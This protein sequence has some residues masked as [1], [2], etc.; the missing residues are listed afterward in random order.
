MSKTVVGLFPQSEDAQ[1]AMRGLETLGINRSSVQVMTSDARD[2]VLN[3]LT[4]AGVPQDDA[5]LYAEGVRRGGALVVGTVEDN[6]ADEAVMVLDRNNTIDI[7][8]LGSRYRETGY[9]GYNESL[10]AYTEPDLTTERDLNKQITV[11]IV[12]EQLVVGKREVQRG[13]ARIH[14]FVTERPVEASVS[15]HE[16]HVTVDRRPVNRAATDADFQNKDITLTETAE[17]AVVGKTARVVE[18]VVV[19][20]TATEHT[21]T[22]RDTVRRTDVEV[23]EIT[24]DTTRK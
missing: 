5:H 23:D 10:P 11:P 15:L 7:D 6:Q 13:G 3:A 22:V 4:S 21:E 19:G 1:G 9:S 8:K 20:K 18:E 14:T 2:K 24:P 12:E 16:E 17:E